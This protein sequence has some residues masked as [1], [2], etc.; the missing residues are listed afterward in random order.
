MYAK[1]HF[2][3]LQESLY[4]SHLDALNISQALIQLVA[5][6]KKEKEKEKMTV[7]KGPFEFK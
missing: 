7:K 6:L 3:I 2:T 1:V 5:D 4:H